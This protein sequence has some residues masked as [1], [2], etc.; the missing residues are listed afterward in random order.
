MKKAWDM[1]WL[2]APYSNIFL[3]QH[4]ACILFYG[5]RADEK[6]WSSKI[7]M[8]LVLALVEYGFVIFDNEELEL[9][10]TKIF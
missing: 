6:A 1:T 5:N 7:Y 9:R 4:C 8:N 10:R 2:E 3:L